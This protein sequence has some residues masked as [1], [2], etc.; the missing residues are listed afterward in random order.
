M[1]ILKM[2]NITITGTK[3]GKQIADI[4]NEFSKAMTR[5]TNAGLNKIRRTLRANAPYGNYSTKNPP[6]PV[7]GIHIKDYLN[8]TNLCVKRFK[9][10]NRTFGG[11]VFF[12]ERYV[13]QIKY[14]VKNKTWP[15][16]IYPTKRKALWF[17]WQNRGYWYWG[18]RVRRK[19]LKGNDFIAKSFKTASNYMHV[20][21]NDELWRITRF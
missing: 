9:Y 15:N 21:F 16:G 7:H 2:I 14:V 18:L 6:P 20:S 11:A 17:Y 4:G 19:P 8:E 3:E 13:P 1:I 10:Q 5:A 12:D